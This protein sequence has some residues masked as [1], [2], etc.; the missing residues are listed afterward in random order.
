MIEPWEIVLS[1]LKRLGATQEDMRDTLIRNTAALEEHMR[2]TEL[3]EEGINL[4]KKD[5]EPIKTHV[6]ALKLIGKWVAGVAALA[7]AAVGIAKLLG[8]V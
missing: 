4:L 6:A 2:R 5:L 1:E 3:A 7:S 8:L